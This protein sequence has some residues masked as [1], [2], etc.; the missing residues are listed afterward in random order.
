MIVKMDTIIQ[1]FEEQ[2]EMEVKKEEREVREMKKEE[3]V[4]EK[5]ENTK[6]SEIE[7]VVDMAEDTIC[8]VIL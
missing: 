2:K 6:F 5:L 8:N 7:E 4:S 3:V 1:E